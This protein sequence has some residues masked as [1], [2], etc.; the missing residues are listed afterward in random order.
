MALVLALSGCASVNLA[1][2]LMQSYVFADFVAGSAASQSNPDATSALALPAFAG[3][4]D[5]R[6]ADTYLFLQRDQ[7]PEVFDGLAALLLGKLS[8]DILGRIKQVLVYSPAKAAQTG[9]N[10]LQGIITGDFPQGILS[11]AL[12]SQA[13]TQRSIEASDASRIKIFEQSTQP[14]ILAA[15]KDNLIAFLYAPNRLAASSKQLQ[16]FDTALDLHAKQSYGYFSKP[17]IALLTQATALPAI[18]RAESQIVRASTGSTPTAVQETFL[19]IAA[20]EAQKSRMLGFASFAL[21]PEA[22]ARAIRLSMVADGAKE[23]ELFTLRIHALAQQAGPDSLR[24]LRT[25]LRSA[26]FAIANQMQLASEVLTALQFSEDRGQL[27][28]DGLRLNQA[29]CIA[30]LGQLIKVLA[31]QEAQLSQPSQSLEVK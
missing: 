6:F 19:S 18:R 31:P 2:D 13:W 4:G 14:I 20:G 11:L 17:Q 15:L 7:G 29:E 9:H 1:P 26:L 16:E 27:V 23:R 8:P 30:L 5:A 3:T 21:G 12:S 28:I 22:L 10:Y 25:R 24:T